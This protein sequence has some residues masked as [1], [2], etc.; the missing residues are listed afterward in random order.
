M[1]KTLTS[2]LTVF[3]LVIILSCGRGTDNNNQTNQETPKALQDDKPVIKSYSRSGSD[4]TEELYAELVDKSQ[5]LKNLE[6]DLFAF[7]PKPNDLKE[8]FDKYNNKSNSFYNSTDYKLTSITD[9]L[10]KKKILAIIT[11]SKNKYAKKTTELNSLL[12]II[13][14]NGATLND[15]HTVMKI[16][17]TLPLIEKYQNDNLPDK[18]EFIDLIKEQEKLIKRIDSNMPKLQ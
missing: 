18:K 17:L 3:A 14:Q 9:S 11:T 8:K 2:I 16:V 6:N 4:L 10:L 1:I 13:S 15:H 5:T 12:N 7:I